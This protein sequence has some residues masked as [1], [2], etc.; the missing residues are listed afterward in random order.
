[1]NDVYF[2]SALLY[3]IWT[4]KCFQKDFGETEVEELREEFAVG[5]LQAERLLHMMEENLM[6]GAKYQEDCDIAHMLSAL[7]AM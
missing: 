3:S 1:M 7:F 2:Y 6:D 5:G 4:G